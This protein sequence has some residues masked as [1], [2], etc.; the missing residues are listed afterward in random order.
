MFLICFKFWF[1]DK[2]VGLVLNLLVLYCFEVMFLLWVLVLLEVVV[3]VMFLVFFVVVFM[4]WYLWIFLYFIYSLFL[5]GDGFIWIDF[6]R[7]LCLWLFMLIMVIE[8][9]F[10]WLLDFF[11]FVDWFWWLVEC[12]CFFLLVDGDLFDFF[13]FVGVFLLYIFG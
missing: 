13:D 1:F 4:M 10:F 12:D 2:Y 5:D 9:S 6:V 8:M 11:F 3:F 7:V